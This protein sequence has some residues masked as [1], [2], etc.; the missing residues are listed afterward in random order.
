[1]ARA[2][3][4]RVLWGA[5]LA[6]CLLAGTVRLTLGIFVTQ[7]IGAIPEGATIVYWRA[8]LSLPFIASADGLALE[9]T[10][11]VSLLSRG[12]MLGQLA[13]LVTDRALLKLPYSRWLYLRST[14][15]LEFDG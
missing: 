11:G 1:M 9:A 6:I 10:G 8:G 5:V 2:M 12:I 7:P 14:G 4:K 13:D 3:R 15:G